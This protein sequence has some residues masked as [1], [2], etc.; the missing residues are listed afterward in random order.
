MGGKIEVDLYHGEAEFKRI[1]PSDIT[2]RYSADPIKIIIY[3]K[4]SV[5]KFTNAGEEHEREI[6]PDE[7][8][9]LVINDV[10]VKAKKKI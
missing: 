6:N 5:L 2:R 3:P 9:P 10:T 1:F 7:I 8:E 4:G